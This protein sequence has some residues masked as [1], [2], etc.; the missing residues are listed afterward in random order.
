MGKEFLK[1]RRR[2]LDSILENCAGEVVRKVIPFRDCDDVP[3]FL[4]RL[5]RLE[6]EARYSK[7]RVEMRY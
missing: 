5:D 7:L 2:M 4:E 1:A 6:K 3:R